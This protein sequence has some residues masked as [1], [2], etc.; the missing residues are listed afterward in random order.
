MQENLIFGWVSSNIQGNF[1]L[2]STWKDEGTEADAQAFYN[3]THEE[4]SEQRLDWFCYEN[5][6]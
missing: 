4:A 5:P 3:A 6:H 2:W 1:H